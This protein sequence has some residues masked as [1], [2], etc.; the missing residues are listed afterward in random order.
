VSL[1]NQRVNEIVVSFIDRDKHFSQ[2]SQYT[3]RGHANIV[4]LVRL[5]D[6]IVH[7]L[8]FNLLNRSLKIRFNIFLE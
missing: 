3:K 7:L 2:L 1:S 8:N 6:H 4:W 5:M